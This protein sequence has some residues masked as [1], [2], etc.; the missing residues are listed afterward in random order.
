MVALALYASLIPPVQKIERDFRSKHGCP[1]FG[2]AITWNCPIGAILA[3]ISD[4]RTVEY[5][6]V[7]VLV[8]LPLGV[9]LERVLSK[10][11]KERLRVLSSFTLHGRTVYR[12]SQ[13]HP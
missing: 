12:I 3:L 6:S 7:S 13:N 5:T 11:C 9:M 1:S 10:G 4:R 8:S 2:K